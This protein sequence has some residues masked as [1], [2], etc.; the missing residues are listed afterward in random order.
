MPVIQTNR[1]CHLVVFCTEGQTYWS[2]VRRRNE[3]VIIKEIER[4]SSFL[5]NEKNL[6]SEV[7]C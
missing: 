6:Q 2:K 7:I 4:I 1:G 5:T 3:N